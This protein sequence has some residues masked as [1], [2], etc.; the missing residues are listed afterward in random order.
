M[1]RF[2][3]T[4]KGLGRIIATFGRAQLLQQQ[5]GR[6]ELCGGTDADRTSAYE[7]IS[8]FMHEA[9]AKIKRR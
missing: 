1:K 6:F 3:C 2:K 4:S 8:L 9:V 7:W 5:N